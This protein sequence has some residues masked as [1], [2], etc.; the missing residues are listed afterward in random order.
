MK[1]EQLGWEEGGRKGGRGGRGTGEEW[2]ESEGI[3]ME[4]DEG[5]RGNDRMEEGWKIVEGESQ[6]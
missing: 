3:S 2:G 4:E 6:A 1:L 5:W